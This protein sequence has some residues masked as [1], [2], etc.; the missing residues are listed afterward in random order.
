MEFLMEDLKKEILESRENQSNR[1]LIEERTSATPGAELLLGKKR[2]YTLSALMDVKLPK[3]AWHVE[4]LVPHSGI[5]VLASQPG[6]FKTWL[7]L[8]IALCVA[9]G[10]PLFNKFKVK[11]S[12]VLIIDE[13][14]R[15]HSIQ[16]RLKK[17]GAKPDL[18][19]HLMIGQNI[20]MEPKFVTKVLDYC[21][22]NEI[23]FVTMDSLVRIHSGEENSASE[24][25]KIFKQIM[26]LGNSGITTFITHHNRKGGGD[27]SAGGQSMRGSSDIL[28]AIDCH[29]MIK[30]DRNLIT[31]SQSKVRY[32]AEIDPINLE[33]RIDDSRASIKY[34]GSESRRQSNNEL[35]E[36]RVI[37]ALG[38]G[39]TS[40][41]QNLLNK[42]NQPEKIIGKVTFGKIIGS[43]VQRGI[44]TCKPGLGNTNLYK[45]AEV[46]V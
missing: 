3:E 12:K 34:L 10:E 25:S 27:Q 2:V 39:A 37:E 44:L 43:M 8:D 40:N 14:N 36:Y 31:L 15:V 9:A 42:I 1:N 18:P 46:K 29:L 23:E 32:A 19:I 11:Q 16:E 17:M 6:S 21:K 26:R 7:L 41:Q 22:S 24:M 45:L 28:A 4:R 35:V 30:R 20:Q 33:I 38:L 13:E 5:T